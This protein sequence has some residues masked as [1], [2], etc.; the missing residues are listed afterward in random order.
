MKVLKEVIKR[1]LVDIEVISVDI[2]TRD[3][4]NYL[5]K[6]EAR[7]NTAFWVK[8]GDEMLYSYGTQVETYPCPDIQH[9]RFWVRPVITFK[10]NIPVYFGETLYLVINGFK[11][12]FDVIG[13]G[14]AIGRQ[15]IN[16]CTCDNIR[17]SLDNWLKNISR[18]KTNEHQ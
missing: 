4:L 10:S 8:D 1:E 3:N 18:R 7:V 13:D 9:S 14:I 11:I 12:P 17:A 5:P 2:P 15:D 16:Y 6:P